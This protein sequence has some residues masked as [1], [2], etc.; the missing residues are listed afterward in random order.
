MFFDIPNIVL[1]HLTVVTE[2]STLAFGQATKG[3][4]WMPWRQKA[5]KGVVSCDK[6]R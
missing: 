4:W 5:M 3:A 6:L 1:Q 2:P